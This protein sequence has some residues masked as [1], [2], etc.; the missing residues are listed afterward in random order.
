MIIAVLSDIHGNLEALEA[1]FRYIDE[2]PVDKIYCLGDIVGYGPNP[3]ECVELIRERS[4]ITLM[5]NHDYAALGLANIEYFNEYAKMSTYWTINNLKKENEDFLRKLPFTHQ[6]GRI[7]LVH[8]SPA[9]PPYW[10]YIL[11]F[12]EAKKELQTFDESICFVGHSHVPVIFSKD[13]AYKQSPFMIE[14]NQKYIVNVG[15]VGQPRDGNAKSCFVVFDESTGELKHVRLEYDVEKTYKK[16]I[17]AGLPVFLA[18]R[19]LKGY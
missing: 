4:D 11:S 12:Q 17:R 18:E 3:N 8:A 13:K 5:G 10:H 7:M 16:I 14:Q 2:N 15:S 9:N 1:V 6:N 19:L